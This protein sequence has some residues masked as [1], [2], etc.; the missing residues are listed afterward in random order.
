MDGISL[1]R[2]RSG[3]IRTVDAQAIVQIGAEASGLDCLRKVDV[4][5]RNDAHVRL[6]PTLFPQPF[7]LAF[8]QSAQRFGLRAQRQFAKLIE[9]PCATIGTFEFCPRVN[10]LP[11]CRYLPTPNSFASIRCAA[12]LRS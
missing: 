4:G 1:G 6:A 11:R 12:V 5:R 2:S 9:K 3:G 10:W 7:D 8:L